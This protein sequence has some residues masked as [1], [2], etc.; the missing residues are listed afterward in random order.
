MHNSA[1]EIMQLVI[2]APPHY[3]KPSDQKEADRDHAKLVFEQHGDLVKRKGFKSSEE[4]V[5]K[6]WTDPEGQLP[7]DP[8]ET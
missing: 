4:L 5:Q 8:N 3:K 1:A 7:R 6:Y 2:V